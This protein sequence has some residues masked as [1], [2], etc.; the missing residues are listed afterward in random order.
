MDE[1]GGKIVSWLSHLWMTPSPDLYQ[2]MGI[3]HHIWLLCRHKIRL[4][5]LFRNFWISWQRKVGKCSYSA[6]DFGNSHFWWFFS[7]W[8]V[9]AQKVVPFDLVTKSSA[10]NKL[11]IDFNWNSGVSAPSRKKPSAEKRV[12][13]SLFSAELFLTKRPIRWNQI[14]AHANVLRS[15]NRTIQEIFK[16]TYAAGWAAALFPAQHHQPPTLM[17]VWEGNCISV[18]TMLNLQRLTRAGWPPYWIYSSQSVLEIKPIN[19]GIVHGWNLSWSRLSFS[20][21]GHLGTA[22][23]K[24]KPATHDTRMGFFSWCS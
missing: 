4:C 9:D 3:S 13:H 2:L 17:A 6:A 16:N 5:G 22:E 21:L 10:V 12:W 8:F 24:G 19:Q 11:V 15:F 1:S 20:V 23:W 18:L 7:N 14:S